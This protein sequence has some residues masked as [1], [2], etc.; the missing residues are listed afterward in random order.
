MVAIVNRQQTEAA[1]ARRAAYEARQSD[2][3][4][5][6]ARTARDDAEAAYMAGLLSAADGSVLELEVELHK[7]KAHRN[8]LFGRC[9]ELERTVKQLTGGRAA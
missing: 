3:Y 5:I 1:K 8:A 9:L 7:V 6:M 4:V 2:P